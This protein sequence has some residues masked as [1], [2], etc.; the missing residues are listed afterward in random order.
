MC[1]C[2]KKR[3]FLNKIKL[4]EKLLEIEFNAKTSMVQ[5]QV[6]KKE[7]KKETEWKEERQKE[8]LIK[9]DE[10]FEHTFLQSE[11]T[12]EHHINIISP[13]SFGRSK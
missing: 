9:M 7:R 6:L 4:K 10:E 12:N 1:T 5:L 3:P 13:N 11:C 2:H 8:N